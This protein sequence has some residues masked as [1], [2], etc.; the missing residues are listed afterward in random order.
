ME[1]KETFGNAFL[2]DLYSP[3]PT[4][5]PRIQIWRRVSATGPGLKASWSRSGDVSF[6]EYSLEMDYNSLFVLQIGHLF[7]GLRGCR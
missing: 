1:E 5:I 6:E 4:D 2:K 7:N 3:F